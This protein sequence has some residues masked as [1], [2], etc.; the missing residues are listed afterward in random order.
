M[1]QD[2]LVDVLTQAYEMFQQVQF[3]F[4]ACRSDYIALFDCFA[5][6]LA[7]GVLPPLDYRSV[8]P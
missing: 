5:R 4:A 3:R 7:E 2:V 8:R 1:L 6:F